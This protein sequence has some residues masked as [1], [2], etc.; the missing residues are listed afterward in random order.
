MWKARC[1]LK[2]SR[3]CGFQP[4]P[5]PVSLTCPYPT[6]HMTTHTPTWSPHPAHPHSIHTLHK[7]MPL[8][9]GVPRR[10]GLGRSAC[11]PGSGLVA[12][13]T[14]NSGVVG[15][16]S[17]RCPGL[18]APQSVGKSLARGGQEGPRPQCR[19]RSMTLLFQGTGSSS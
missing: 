13:C 5:Q 17:G 3:I 9:P 16:Q 11:S 8:W 15:M 1:K 10:I 7:Q 19:V 4:K 14:G 2:N 12:T 6:L 18:Q